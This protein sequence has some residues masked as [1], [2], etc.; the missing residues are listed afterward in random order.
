MK[1][2]VGF[3]LAFLAGFA[4]V[5]GIATLAGAIQWSTA[6]VRGKLD[7]REQIHASGDYRIQAYEH[8]FNLC[9]SVQTNEQSLDAQYDE[10][11][12]AKDIGDKDNEA[13]ILANI[14][15]IRAARQDAINQYNADAHKD[16]TLGQF[17]ASSL[18]YQLD[19]SYKK[20][21][22]TSCTV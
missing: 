18:P 9:A 10:L 21:V 12:A 11:N 7:A 15:G 13:R 8:F 5:V 3:I 22:H 19:T 20:G 16:Y 6:D 2:V 4:I 17:R 14:A 1:T